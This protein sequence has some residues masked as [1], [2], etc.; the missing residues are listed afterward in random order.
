MT[1]T[2]ANIRKISNRLALCLGVLVVVVVSGALF[3]NYG[4]TEDIIAAPMAAFAV[5]VVGGFVGLQR[6]LK[7]MSADDL[8]LLANSW[9]Y[10]CLSPLVGGIL[11][12]VLYV[13]FLSTLVSGDLF[14][15]FVPD[16][17]DDR[18]GFSNIF[19]VHGTGV[20]YAKML[21]W[22]FIA[23][24]SERFVTDIVSKFENPPAGGNGG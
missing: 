13:L 16:A 21:F 4:P 12:I 15:K 19:A 9:V 7:T 20:D 14:P 3:S 23:G 1:D 24:F 8:T 22:S 11:A 17:S 5:G 2:L 6:R 10:V 18:K